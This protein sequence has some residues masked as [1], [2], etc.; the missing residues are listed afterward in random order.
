MDGI[1][2]L[3]A[4][5]NL[6][7]TASVNA[8]KGTITFKVNEDEVTVN[9]TDGK[10]TLDLIRIPEGSYSITATYKD[11]KDNYLESSAISEDEDAVF[12][13]TATAPNGKVTLT[14]NNETYTENLTDGKATFTV[15]NLTSGDYPY[16]VTFEDDFYYAS[17][18]TE[19]II[20]VKSDN[21]VISAPDLTKYFA[22]P[23]R[24]LVTVTDKDGNPLENI[25][26]QIVLNGK[27][28]NR[29]TNASGIAGMNIN[30]GSGNYTAV[31][32][33]VGDAEHKSVN[34]TAN[35]TVL[36][37][38]F[39]DDVTKIQKGPEPYYATFLD[40]AGNYL[41]DGTTVKFNINGVMYERKVSGNKGL[42]KL[43]LNLEAGTYTITAMNPVTG[44]NAANNITIKPR[45]VNNSDVTKFYRNG[46]Q[47][48][49]TV[50]G[51]DGNPVGANITVKFNINGVFYERQTNAS[52]V[53]RLNLNLEPGK[54]IITAEYNG[55]RVSNNITILP[56]LSAKDIDMKYKDGTKFKAT[57]VNGTGAPYP[58]ETVTFN[59]NGVFYNRV[60]D[61]DGIAALNINLMPG[62][63][64]ITSSY[65]GANIANTVTVKP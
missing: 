7:I 36:P 3:N 20:N 63:Y 12:N 61:K 54:Y 35:I 8:T 2:D 30:L 24:F 47:Y 10:A 50:L 46:T 26:I 60:T 4:G 23:D 53:A 5:D 14:I 18:S 39:G 62:K 1:A 55:C 42:A 38:V 41:K 48:Y 44:E 9:I 52:G 58:G 45:L 6:T 13:V 11:A 56:V 29:T 16:K 15:S 37:T 19:G 59:I 65:N 32:S 33:Y 22:S 40:S 17:N 64:I 34:V 43:N 21:L 57:L 28:Y 31:V 49:V 27:A 51:D 25:T